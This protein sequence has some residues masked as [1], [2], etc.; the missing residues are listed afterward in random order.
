M[1]K[2][3]LTL[4][5]D[6]FKKEYKWLK[7]NFNIGEHV[8]LF[9]GNTF[10]TIGENGIACTMD[11]SLPFFELPENSIGIDY[12]NKSYRIFM[13]EKT[14]SYVILYCKEFPFDPMDL[15]TK[16]QTMSRLSATDKIKTENQIM[17]IVIE[18]GNFVLEKSQL[19]DIGPLF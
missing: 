10:D 11:G 9:S 19:E 5:R 15:L 4:T 7:R 12:E 8:Y 16:T 17:K 13:T 1:E 3:K 2:L 14:K 6:V 18:K